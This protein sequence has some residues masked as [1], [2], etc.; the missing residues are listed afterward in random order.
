ELT[1]PEQAVSLVRVGQPVKLTVDAYPGE[2]FDAKVR[3]VSPSV[4]ADQRAM[5][6]EAIAPNPSGRLK[7]GLFTTA[8]IQQPQSAPALLA[9][10]TAVETISGTSRVYVIKDGKV[11]ERIVTTGEKVGDR[12]EITSGVAAGDVVAADPKGRLTDGAA[13]K[14]RQ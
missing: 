5:T 8:S 3:F 9:P 1:I 7:P 10:V 12:V 14:A 2:V 13:V 4:R 6:I 11:E